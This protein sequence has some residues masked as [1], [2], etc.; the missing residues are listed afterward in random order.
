MGVPEALGGSHWLSHYLHPVF[1]ASH[2]LVQAHHLSHATEYILMGTV[3]AFTIV[4]I[5]IAYVLYISKEQVPA[6]EGQSTSGVQRLLA[7]KYYI[8]ELYNAIVVKPLYWFS[9]I[10]DSIIERLG[11][12]KLVN[13]FGG[14]V[15]AGSKV[16]RLLQNGGIGYYIF[17][18]VI[19][20]VL[21]LAYAVIR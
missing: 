5:I 10:F 1:A 6:A 19:G 12:D 15:V 11:I 16:T 20:I 17:M 2:N 13:A 7:N 8:D 9:G 3:V 4:M 14:S 18:M 21:I